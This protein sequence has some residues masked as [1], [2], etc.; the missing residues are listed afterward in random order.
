MEG[1]ERGEEGER[2]GRRGE[3]GEGEGRGGACPTNQTRICAA[4]IAVRY[5]ALSAFEKYMCVILIR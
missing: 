2:G 5:A 3:G 1:R 4:E